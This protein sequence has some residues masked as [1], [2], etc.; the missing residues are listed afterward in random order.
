MTNPKIYL[1]LLMVSLYIT[2]K[3]IRHEESNYD[4]D[5]PTRSCN[6]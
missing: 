6:G 2:I 5:A 3:N 4:F 1:F